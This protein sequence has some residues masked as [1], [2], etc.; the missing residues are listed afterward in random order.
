M[1]IMDRFT[2]VLAWI[3]CAGMISPISVFGGQP[4]APQQTRI[5]DVA[6]NSGTFAGQVVDHQ[7][8]AIA[9]AAVTVGQPGAAAVSTVTDASGRFEVANLAG[10]VYQITAADTISVCRIWAENSAPPVATDGLLVVSNSHVV[11]G[12]CNTCNTGGGYVAGAPVEGG[13]VVNGPMQ[14]GPMQGGPVQGGYV[15]GGYI[16][17]GACGPACGPA[18]ADC[19]PVAGGGRGGVVGI[20]SNPWFVGAVIAAAIA[21]PLAV[22]D[23]DDDDAS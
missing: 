19:G 1:K 5:Q 13:Y 21:I 9:G 20:I 4:V 22:S 17:G 3:A 16:D 10:G 23:N 12:Q 2:L 18:C 7:G 14:G 11:R 8:A 6:L 15:D